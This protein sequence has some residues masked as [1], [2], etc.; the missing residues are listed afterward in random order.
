MINFINSVLSCHLQFLCV[1]SMFSRLKVYKDSK[2]SLYLIYIPENIYCGLF[3][4]SQFLPSY[5]GMWST[6]CSFCTKR[7]V[8]TAILMD[9]SCIVI[10]HYCCDANHPHSSSLY[11]AT[12]YG[13]LCPMQWIHKANFFFPHHNNDSTKSTNQFLSISL[14]ILGVPNSALVSFMSFSSYTLS[15]WQTTGPRKNFQLTSQN[16]WT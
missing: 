9:M 16:I 14:L 2:K 8:H 10:M 3:E 4:E 5:A 11:M 13:Q 7:P 1:L 12:I 15:S 6:V